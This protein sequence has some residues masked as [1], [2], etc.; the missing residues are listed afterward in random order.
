MWRYE[1]HMIC[2]RCIQIEKKH[3]TSI[4]SEIKIKIRNIK[5]WSMLSMLSPAM[6]NY[7]NIKCI[8]QRTYATFSFVRCGFQQFHVNEEQ[9]QFVVVAFVRNHVYIC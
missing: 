3:Y 2:N 8:R 4:V 1:L 7:A 6:T 9:I 5:C